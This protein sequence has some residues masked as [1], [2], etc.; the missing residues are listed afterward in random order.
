MVTLPDGIRIDMRWK[1]VCYIKNDKMLYFSIEPMMNCEA[2][3]YFPS[4]RSWSIIENEFSQEERLEIIFLLERIAWKRKIKIV[5][6]DITPQIFSNE[7]DIVITGSMESTQAG[8]KIERDYLFDPESP[9]TAEHVHELYMSL[10]KKFAEKTEGVVTIYAET[11]LEN[12][13]FNVVTLPLLRENTNV[14]LNY[15]K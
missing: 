5:V 15:V 13:I 3:V 10:E 14:Q 11:L 2:V 9:L 7:Y 6:L 12:S 4:I 1:S 8:R